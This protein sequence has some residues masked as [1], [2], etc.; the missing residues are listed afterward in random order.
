[1][2]LA[3]LPLPHVELHVPSIPQDYST[4]H[5]SL[6]F[7]KLAVPSLG[8]ATHHINS[9]SSHHTDSIVT[10]SEAYAS[11]F[12][13]ALDSTA[14]SSLGHRPIYP[15]VKPLLPPCP[16]NSAWLRKEAVRLL[17]NFGDRERCA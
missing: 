13:R 1:M 3:T 17:G 8:A 15:Y 7:S 14:P 9:H 5:L 10:E 4:E 6:A 12:C 2:V 11:V 16:D